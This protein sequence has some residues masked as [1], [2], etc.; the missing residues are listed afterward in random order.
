MTVVASWALAEEIAEVLRRPK[1]RRYRIGEDD[2]RDVLL[3]LAP[4]LPT[5]DVRVEVRDPDDTPVIAAAIAGQVDAIVTGDKD[6]LEDPSLV[7]WLAA[8]GIDVVTPAELLDRL[9]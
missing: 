6:L 8:R 4:L 2:I 1:L 9:R 5:V 3:L 7:T